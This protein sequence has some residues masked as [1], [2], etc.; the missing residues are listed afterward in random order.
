M[1]TLTVSISEDR[2]AKLKEAAARL[3]VEPELLVRASID[4]LLAK[5]QS[6][7][8]QA[9]AYVLNKNEELYKRLS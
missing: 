8:E 1:T 4:E 2:L 9:V 3:G 5:P 6:D 7:F